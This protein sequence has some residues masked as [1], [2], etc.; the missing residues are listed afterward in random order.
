MRQNYPYPTFPACYPSSLP[1]YYRYWWRYCCILEEVGWSG[2]S[3]AVSL[4]CDSSRTRCSVSGYPLPHAHLLYPTPQEGIRL[5]QH[6]MGEVILPKFQN[7][8]A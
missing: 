7:A 1:S 8:G 4:V 5:F 6:P 3:S 2:V